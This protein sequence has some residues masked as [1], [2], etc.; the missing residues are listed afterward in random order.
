[1]S[2]VGGR[3]RGRGLFKNSNVRSNNG[4]T[5]SSSRISSSPL[6]HTLSE[7]TQV[8]CGLYTIRNTRNINLIAVNLTLDSDT[9][10][11]FM[12]LRQLWNLCMQIFKLIK[13]IVTIMMFCSKKGA[14]NHSYV[15]PTF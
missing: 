11:W 7:C 10:E 15:I 3:G 13:S 5:E 1:M 14:A 12:R 4:Y 8:F 6:V 9:E 2:F